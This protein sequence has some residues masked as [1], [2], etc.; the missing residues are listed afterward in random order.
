MVETEDLYTAAD[1]KRVREQ[2]LKEQGGY[3][4]ITGLKITSTAVLD[5]RHDDEQLVR[6]V[7]HRQVNAFEGKINNSWDRLM[8]WWYPEDNLP[9]VLRLMADYLEK[10]PDRR[11]RHVHWQ[12]KVKVKFN[13]LNAASQNKV[14]EQ[15][16]GTSQSNPAKRKD[17]F[18]K[19]VLDRKLGYNTIMQAI[20]EVKETNV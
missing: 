18:G 20:K 8:K 3:C 9:S 2:L 19:L 12:K 17:L 5:H 1:V 16:G 14:L 11:F 7:L 15:L 6:A 10:E 13:Q 4:A